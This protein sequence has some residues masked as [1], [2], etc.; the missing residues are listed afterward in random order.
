MSEILVGKSDRLLYLEARYANRHGMIAGAT[1]TG[2]SVSLMLL[3]EGFS[4]LGVPVFLADVKGAS[5]ALDLADFLL[6]HR[7]NHFLTSACLARLIAGRHEIRLAGR[8]R[9]RPKQATQRYRGTLR[10]ESA[11]EKLDQRAQQGDDRF[12]HRFEQ[13]LAS[14]RAEQHVFRD[15]GPV[16]ALLVRNAGGQLG[17]SSPRG[18]LGSMSR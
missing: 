11:F 14:R 13:A 12:R 1:G 10:R 15:V 8:S 2:K 3:A 17:R 5:P 6:P 9:R 16:A 4:K 7:R 18:V